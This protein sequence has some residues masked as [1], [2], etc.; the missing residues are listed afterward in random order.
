MVAFF[1]DIKNLKEGCSFSQAARCGNILDKEFSGGE[2]HVKG[3]EFS[4]QHSLTFTNGLELPLSIVYTHTS[5]EFRTSFESDFP[6]WGIIEAGD[7]LPYLPT[8]QLSLTIGLISDL[9]EVNLIARYIDTMKEASGDEV[10]LSDV[11]TSA[12]SIVDFSASYDLAQFGQVYLKIDNI[13]DV[14][15]IVSRRPYGARP[16][17]PQQM[18]IGYQYSF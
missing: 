5:S 16:S 13:F 8:N 14:Q 4:A 1:N 15:E 9:W 11:T 10:L 12:Y 18:Q 7:D 2:V 17:K 3:I 6:M